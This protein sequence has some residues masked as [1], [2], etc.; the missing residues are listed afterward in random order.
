MLLSLL[1]WMYITV[2]SLVWGNI[3]L[4]LASRLLKTSFNSIHPVIICFAGLAVTGTLASY[5][6]LLLPLQLAAHLCLLVPVIL[7][8]FFTQNRVLVGQQLRQLTSGYNLPTILLLVACIC[9]T[10]VLSTYTISHPDTLAYHGQAIKWV[11]TYKAVPGL[12]HLKYEVAMNSLWFSSLAVFRFNFIQSNPFIFLNGCVISWFYLFIIQRL[13][14]NRERKSLFIFWLLLLIYSS[15]SWT[16]IRLT[17]AS[18]SPDFIATLFIW[19]AIFAYLQSRQH[20]SGK[21]L[22]VLATL[23][24]CAAITTK[25]SAIMITLLPVAIMIQLLA[26]KRT[27]FTLGALCILCIAPYLLHNFISSGYLLYPSSLFD[28]FNPDWKLPIDDLTTFQHYIA[29]YARIPVEDNIAANQLLQQSLTEWAPV[30][31]K[32]LAIADQALLITVT[33]LL[34]G[35]LFCIP[36]IA[37]I[38]DNNF[39]IALA[40]CIAGSIAWFILAPDPRFGTGFLIPLAYLLYLGISVRFN[41]L[42]LVTNNYIFAGSM[43][44]SI[45]CVGTYTSYRLMHYFTS[46]QLLL[47]NGIKKQS[48]STFTCQGVVMHQTLNPEECGL[49]P[50]PCVKD[51]CNTFQLRGNSVEDGFKGKH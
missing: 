8:F 21:M 31:W 10:L 3:F 17:A 51:S 46:G 1:V 36:A 27:T 14:A 6:S 33:L 12:A 13:A 34:A 15:L 47:P 29:G 9:M 41:H 22:S 20:S 30:W 38:L 16:Q 4:L 25:L 26:G 19:A 37:G 35:A 45:I 18:A 5:I 23:F 2:V 48:Y 40:V 44:L 42:K 11:E 32:H 50:V 28:L 43:I 7:F 39:R 24:S 49:T